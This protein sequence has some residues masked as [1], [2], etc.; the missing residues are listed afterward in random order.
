VDDGLGLGCAA[1]FVPQQN[2]GGFQLSLQLFLG[3][4]FAPSAAVAG[5]KFLVFDFAD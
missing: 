5:E 1:Q 3:F 2:Q 4:S